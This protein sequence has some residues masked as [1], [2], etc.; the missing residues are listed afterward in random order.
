MTETEKALEILNEKEVASEEIR[1]EGKVE[2][3]NIKVERSKEEEDIRN[4]QEETQK[5]KMDKSGVRPG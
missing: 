5:R 1:Q 4:K 2:K 3:L